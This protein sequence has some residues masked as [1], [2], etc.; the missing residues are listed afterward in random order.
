[1]FQ[2]PQSPP[3]LLTYA[4]FAIKFFE[5]VPLL[6]RG[7]TQASAHRRKCT[8]IVSAYQGRLK[9]LKPLALFRPR[10]MI[11][12]GLWLALIFIWF[13]F[14]IFSFN[15]PGWAMSPYIAVTYPCSIWISL[16]TLIFGTLIIVGTLFSFARVY[17]FLRFLLPQPEGRLASRIDR[18]TDGYFYIND[19][20]SGRIAGRIIDGVLDHPD[21]YGEGLVYRPESSAEIASSNYANYVFFGELVEAKAGEGRAMDRWG[22]I[23][24]VY[25]KKPDLFDPAQLEQLAKQH[26]FAKTLV[27]QMAQYSP[28]RDPFVGGL[29][30]VLDSNVERLSKRFHCDARKI[31][32]PNP[33]NRILIK[34]KLL[35][36]FG[37]I[38]KRLTKFEPYKTRSGNRL[39]LIKVMAIRRVW[40]IPLKELEFPFAAWQSVFLL[41]SG[42]IT[43]D[44]EEFDSY[45]PDFAWFRNEALRRLTELVWKALGRRSE[46]E[47]ERIKTTIKSALD[48]EGAMILT[49]TF[50]WKVGADFCR[51]NSC[52]EDGTMC[53]FGDLAICKPD[54]GE[55]LFRYEA[56][57]FE[58]K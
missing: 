30:D 43:Y 54:D 5:A 14:I 4:L 45:D 12:T 2:L 24:E 21:W 35:S 33:W 18:D 13:I 1:M 42:I 44:R 16:G 39:V 20:E 48:P 3:V 41:R 34:L 28:N 51:V 23:T 26:T 11:V 47:Q 37:L 6:T 25:K 53:P 36:I 31:G 52:A 56:P 38:D 40:Y 19:D 58:R 50:L 8:A 55:K 10:L 32:Q 15:Y 46:E 7:L 57:N 29:Y 17:S 49:D 22:W 27:D 9:W